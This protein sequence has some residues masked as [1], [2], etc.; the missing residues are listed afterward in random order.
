MR[1][2]KGRGFVGGSERGAG[3][4][5]KESAGGVQGGFGCAG[6]VAAGQDRVLVSGLAGASVR[7]AGVQALLRG[8]FV[9]AGGA[10][11]AATGPARHGRPA[12]RDGRPNTTI[13]ASLGICEDTAL[14]G[15][16]G[17]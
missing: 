9:E 10:H 15:V 11:P 7:R 3:V 2:K 16:G 14:G 13:A 6:G 5:E 12:G 17:R 8:R 1:P 4:A